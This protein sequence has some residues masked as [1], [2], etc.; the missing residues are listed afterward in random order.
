MHNPFNPTFGDVPRFFL[1]DKQDMTVDELVKVIT[2][3]DFGRS[4]LITGVRGAGKTAF[5]MQL[6][7]QIQTHH[8]FIW[9]DLINREGI[10]TSLAQQIKEQLASPLKRVV[11]HVTGVT[12]GP[13]GVTRDEEAA[14]VDHQLD[15]LFQQVKAQRKRVL[16]TIDEVTNDKPMRNFI[17]LF[18]AFKRKEYPI[19][20][21]MTGVP[22]LILSLQNDNRL[23]FLLRSEK[24]M[25]GQLNQLEMARAYEEALPQL[26]QGEI[27]RMVQ[28]TAGYSYAFQ[29]LGYLVYKALNEQQASPKNA[30][31]SVMRRYQQELFEKAYQK[32]FSDL[33]EQDRA[34][35]YAVRQNRSLGEAAILMKKSNVYVAQYR[36]RMIER[37][38]I[39]PST[40]GHVRFVLPNFEDY[41]NATQNQDSLFYLGY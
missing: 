15:Y 23:T 30:V 1:P 2:T 17:Q 5:M 39:Q 41:L 7:K 19:F 20:V 36:R 14:T 40:N 10:L 8:D 26:P 29:L 16:I 27:T 22:D 38:I 37:G 12:L 34:Y 6:V 24:I 35:L 4:F 9:A 18:N 11:G 21:V 31:A 32:I 13:V 33:S 28:M 25:L 3:S